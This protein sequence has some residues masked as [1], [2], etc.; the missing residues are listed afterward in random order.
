MAKKDHKRLES[1][2]LIA[3]TL[4]KSEPYGLQSEVIASAIEEIRNNP[5]ISLYL[6]LQRGLEDWDI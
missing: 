3:E 5:D 2:D 4:K 6:A 1:T